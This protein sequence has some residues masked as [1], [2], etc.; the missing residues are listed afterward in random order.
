M[1]RN[2]NQIKTPFFGIE[3]SLSGIYNPNLLSGITDEPDLG[4][5]YLTI[6]SYFFSS[7]G[8]TSCLL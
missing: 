1:G 3:Q 6:N 7:Y 2:L 8:E 5:P 4:N